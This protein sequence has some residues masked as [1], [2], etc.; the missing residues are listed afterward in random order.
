MGIQKSALT[1]NL[2]AGAIRI[3]FFILYIWGLSLLK[4]FQ[5]VFEYHGAEHKTITAWENKSPLIPSAVINF[6]RF[7][8]R[9]GT[10]FILIVALFAVMTFALSD[11]LYSIFTGFPP[12]LLK[13]FALHFSLLPL[14]AGVSYELLRF[15]AKTQEHPLTRALIQPGLWLQRITTREPNLEQLAVAIVALEDA[16]EIRTPVSGVATIATSPEAF[17]SRVS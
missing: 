6:T 2:V 9:C 11:T 4:D 17:P 7:H 14:V 15:S 13:R 16:L 8:P 5:R 12:T 1:F 10:S 3:S